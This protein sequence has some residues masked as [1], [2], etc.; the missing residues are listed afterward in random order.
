LLGIN[1]VSG[2]LTDQ[3]LKINTDN[4]PGVGIVGESLQFQ[5][6]ADLY[7]LDG[8]M[9]LAT[10]Y[11]GSATATIYPAVTINSVGSNGGK[12]IAFTYDLA[13]SIVYTRQGNPLWSGQKR[14]GQPGPIR[15]DDLYFPDWVDFDKVE[16]PQADEQQR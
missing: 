4:G 9:S 15:S 16:I 3:Y 5:G 6:T 11:S 12:A 8:A 13:R 2:T 14:D 10:L 1:R 7:A